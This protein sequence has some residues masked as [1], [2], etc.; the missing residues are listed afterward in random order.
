MNDDGS[1]RDFLQFL[2][3]HD[4]PAFLRRSQGVNDAWKEAI[5]ECQVAREKLLEMPRL[6]LG[7]LA[8]TAQHDWVEVASLLVDRSSADRLR[9]YHDAWQPVLRT[10]VAAVRNSKLW[11]KP[12]QEL[13]TSFR[14][15]N[16]R[17]EEYANAFDY[18]RVNALRDGYNKF[19]V[20]EKSCAF[21]SDRIG[22]E[23]FVELQPASSADMM[24]ELPLLHV[25]E[26]QDSLTKTQA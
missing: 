14:R 18:R 5:R 1:R 11:I 8:E 10:D 15:F 13:I 16:Q 17:W 19:Y 24:R 25:P 6:R 12:I 23:G 2:A 26:L 21:D 3:E 4:V 9:E 22:A 20:I 7:V